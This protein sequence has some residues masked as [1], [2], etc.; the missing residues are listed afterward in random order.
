M[1]ELNPPAAASAD[2]NL[3]DDEFIANEEYVGQLVSMGFSQGKAEK[4]LFY[5]GN[6]STEQAATWIIENPGATSDDDS[7]S[8]DGLGFPSYKMVFVVNHSLGMGVGKVAA[9]VAHATLGLHKDLLQ[10][11]EKYGQMLLAWEMSGQT[12]IVLKGESTEQLKE[13]HVKARAADLP[14]CLIRD[15]GRTQIAS[16][17]TTVLSIVGLSEK[18]NEITGKLRLL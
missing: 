1:D 7:S 14:C 18:V 10:N 3:T 6:H 5:T 8:S 15:A 17:S 12:K 13:L 16:G 9:Q 4:A 2:P 11:Q